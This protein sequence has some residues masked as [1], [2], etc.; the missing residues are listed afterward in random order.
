MVIAAFCPHCGKPTQDSA[1]CPE[2]GRSTLVALAPSQAGEPGTAQHRSWSDDLDRVRKAVGFAGTLLVL[3]ILGAPAGLATL[4][5]GAGSADPVNTF[6]AVLLVTLPLSFGILVWAIGISFIET[7]QAGLYWTGAIVVG[8]WLLSFALGGAIVTPAPGPNVIYAIP[9]RIL[10]G[11]FEA[12][13]PIGFIGAFIAGG[14]LA[15]LYYDVVY[16][17][18]FGHR[19]R[20]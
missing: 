12:Y 19:P 15:Y 5:G 13:G 16:P 3:L 20:T 9:F 7:D 6:I 1:T 17:R 8:A 10:A 11:F 2:C 18:V 14:T 4:L